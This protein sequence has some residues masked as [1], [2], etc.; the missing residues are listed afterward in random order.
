MI[1]ILFILLSILEGPDINN[2]CDVTLVCTY[3]KLKTFLI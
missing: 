3:V 2:S 1:K